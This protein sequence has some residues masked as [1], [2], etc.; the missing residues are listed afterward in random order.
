[1]KTKSYLKVNINRKI[2]IPPKIYD[3]IHSNLGIS[4]IC[5]T[6]K[7]YMI[8][9]I[10]ENFLSQDYIKKELIIILNYDRQNLDSLNK[11][12]ISFDN[13]KI[14]NLNSKYSL[15]KCLNYA[16]DKS[17]Y[18][19]IAKFD[20]DDYYAPKYLS[21]SIKAFYYTDASLVGKSTIYVYFKKHKIL[22]IKN[23]NRDCRFV[24][25]VAGSTLMFKKSIFE[26]IS[27]QDKNLGEDIGFC[28]DCIENGF[29]IYSTNKNHFV[30]IRNIENKHTW[31]INNSYLYF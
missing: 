26:K 16:V 13:I 27:F 2:Y 11:K 15:G 31:K 14:Y 19:I 6:N 21:D 7:G 23:I 24:N 25:R 22:A 5:C 28:N 12:I 17:T 3:N 30:Y 18:P 4:V 20:D 8:N 10:L 29:K 9:N 1:M